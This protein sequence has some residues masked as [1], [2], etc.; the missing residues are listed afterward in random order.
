MRRLPLLT[1]IICAGFGLAT[2]PTLAL[3]PPPQW[4][5]MRFAPNRMAIAPPVTQ[6]ELGAEFTM[7]AWVFIEKYQPN[8]YLLGKQHPSGSD[9]YWS[10]ILLLSSDGLH[11]T[12]VE[13]TGNAGEASSVTSST[14]LPLRTWVHVAGSLAG[15]T[16]RLFIDGV[17]AASGPSLGPPSPNPL[18]FG[19]GGCATGTGGPNANFTGAMRQVRVWS[20]ALSEPE[21]STN[22][23]KWLKGNEPGL[24]AYWPLDDGKD[25]TAHDLGQLHLALQ[26]GLDATPNWSDPGWIHTAI[27][28]QGPFFVG[29][30]PF[31]AA[32]GCGTDPAQSCMN[33]SAVVD[34]D[35]DGSP[36]LLLT[37]TFFSSNLRFPPA[38]LVALQNDG[39]G[40][41]ADVTAT[42]CPGVHTRCNGRFGLVSD[43]NGDGLMDVFFEDQGPDHGVGPGGQNILLFQT[44]DGRMED[45]TS[46]HLP[47]RN[48]FTH[49]TCAGDFNGDGR[50]DIFVAPIFTG[51]IAGA[52][53]TGP[54]LLR[55]DGHGL[56]SRGTEGLP[57]R[58]L[59][60]ANNVGTAAID[61]NRDGYSDLVIGGGVWE[62]RDTLL[63]N[64]GHGNLLLAPENALPLRGPSPVFWNSMGHH[65]TTGDLDADG[66]PDLLYYVPGTDGS[67]RWC[68]F[69]NN[70]NGTFRDASNQILF[71][72]EDAQSGVWPRIAD[73]NADGKPDFVIGGE[74]R[75]FLNTGGSR[76]VS[77]NEFW[78]LNLPG[79]N[80]ESGDFDGDGSVDVVVVQGSS[81]LLL[82]Q[83]K[84]PDATLLADAPLP[85]HRHLSH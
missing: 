31:N 14:E 39:H 28:D 42:V 74:P 61:V 62:K 69:L 17:E 48:V 78:P 76:F 85:V 45:V 60:Q 72:P 26:R 44:P 3:E 8:A 19:V 66:W 46:T 56:F 10:Y 32:P 57:D 18:P 75:L 52:L 79:G 68:L 82:R 24:L 30:E 58:I 55:N 25:Q 81:I 13:S 7:E 37:T 70:H 6:L 80:L 40:H 33:G 20:R 49:A 15:G 35:H 84:A 23:G 63:L 64:D 43:F 83:L 54:R 11:L 4:Y 67:T 71:N 50:D 41:F 27:V 38:P 59:R 34:F 22:A 47:M 21:L 29:D 2:L 12:L 36:D 73:F 9:P 5:A 65:I 53:A 16:L 1:P 51:S 77:G